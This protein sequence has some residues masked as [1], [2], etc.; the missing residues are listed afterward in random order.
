MPAGPCRGVLAVGRR[1]GLQ[2]VAE[3]AGEQ[4][5]VAGPARGQVVAVGH[6]EGWRVVGRGA[7]RGEG[8]RAALELAA[9]VVQGGF[10]LVLT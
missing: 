9:R 6:G 2:E 10:D 3:A 1:G 4:V 7:A 5:G 8:Q